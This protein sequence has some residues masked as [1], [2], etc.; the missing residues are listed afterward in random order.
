MYL[1]DNL[2]LSKSMQITL[3]YEM[4]QRFTFLQLSVTFV[5]QINII[6]TVASL[7]VKPRHVR[8]QAITS[9]SIVLRFIQCIRF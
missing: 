6:I 2:V 8:R 7:L 4:V 9:R 5:D 1:K 3:P